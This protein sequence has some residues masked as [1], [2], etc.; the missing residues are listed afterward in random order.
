MKCAKLHVGKSCNHLWFSLV[1]EQSGLPVRERNASVSPVHTA[2]S[3]FL[4][5]VGGLKFPFRAWLV[6]E[7][8]K[9]HRVRAEIDGSGD[10][11]TGNEST[12]LMNSTVLHLTV[13]GFTWLM[14]LGLSERKRE[15]KVEQSHYRTKKVLHP[16][17]C[18]QYAGDWVEL[19]LVGASNTLNALL[20]LQFQQKARSQCGALLL[21]TCKA[22]C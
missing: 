7:A 21:P 3:V 1:L 22:P 16:E 9:W 6:G 2:A 13:S 19:Y 18:T 17:Q 4:C 12:R 5:Q 15:V 20:V 14:S 10:E 8:V 11:L